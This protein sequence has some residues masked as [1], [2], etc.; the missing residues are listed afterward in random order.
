MDGFLG[1][2]TRL[3][4][5]LINYTSPF[6]DLKPENLLLD[7]QGHIKITDFG[8][9]K[10]VP[11]ITWTLCGTPDYLAPEVIQSKG[12]GK[13]KVNIIQSRYDET[14]SVD[15]WHSCGL[16]VPGCLGLRNACRVCHSHRHSTSLSSLCNSL[17]IFSHIGIHLSLTM[18]IL[19]CTKRFLPEKSSIPVTLIPMPRISCAAY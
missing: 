6:R 10:H 16:V 15:T 13:G 9:A 1:K 4:Y 7:A 12:Y 17:F 11:D 14:D 19:N 5:R 2:V 8:F 3:D 18:I